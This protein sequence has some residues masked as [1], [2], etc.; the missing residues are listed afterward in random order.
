MKIFYGILFIDLKVLK[1]FIQD[2]PAAC[3]NAIHR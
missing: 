3:R 1:K 2:L